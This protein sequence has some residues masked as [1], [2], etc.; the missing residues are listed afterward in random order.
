MT[1]PC[2]PARLIITPEEFGQIVVGFV[3]YYYRYLLPDGAKDD[4]CITPADFVVGTLYPIHDEPTTDPALW[5]DRLLVMGNAPIFGNPFPDESADDFYANPYEAFKVFVQDHLIARV[6][7]LVGLEN[8]FVDLAALS[9]DHVNPSEI[10]R[11]L[12][13]MVIPPVPVAVQLAK[14]MFREPPFEQYRLQRRPDLTD[15]QVTAIVN[16]S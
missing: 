10:I 13:A 9:R 15:A 8:R 3:E 7:S 2:L 6:E 5:L 11:K 1:A 16:R 12:A 14:V 4:R